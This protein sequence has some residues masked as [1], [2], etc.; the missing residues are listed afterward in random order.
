MSKSYRNDRS[1]AGHSGG[2]GSL[3]K[4]SQRRSNGP[5]YRRTDRTNSDWQTAAQIDSE[6]EREAIED[7]WASYGEA[8]E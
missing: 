8:A 4:A 7:M 6:L 3:P 5:A 2:R 1:E